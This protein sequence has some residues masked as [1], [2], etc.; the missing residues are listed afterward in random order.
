MKKCLLNDTKPVCKISNSKINIY[1]FKCSTILLTDESNMN[2]FGQCIET[3]KPWLERAKHVI[4]LSMYP[5]AHYRGSSVKNRDETFIKALN[6]KIETIDELEVPNFVSG[7]G[8][9]AASWRL[10]SNLSFEIYSIYLCSIILDV[11][12]VRPILKLLEKLNLPVDQNYTYSHVDDN[13]L[14]M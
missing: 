6:S 14:Y 7:L 11:S 4:I 3:I 12:T 10:F 9:G 13:V 8:A 2:K 5:Q 1:E